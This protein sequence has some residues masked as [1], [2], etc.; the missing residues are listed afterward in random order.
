MGRL[1]DFGMDNQKYPDW[2][3]IRE[4]QVAVAEATPY[5]AWID[6]DDLNDG[7]R[8]EGGENHNFLHY[9]PGDYET[10]GGR[11]AESAIAL[12][13]RRNSSEGLPK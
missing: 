6:T 2:T 1:S 9:R 7:K 11:F 8:G 10:L 3:M 13:R 4:I 5:G 12:I